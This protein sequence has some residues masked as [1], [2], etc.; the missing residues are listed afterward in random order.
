MINK[1][2]DSNQDTDPKWNIDETHLTVKSVETTWLEQTPEYLDCKCETGDEAS[3][4]S[5][6]ESEAIV[7][8]WEELDPDLM[9]YILLMFQPAVT[10]GMKYKAT[11]W[12]LV[13]FE[14]DRSIQLYGVPEPSMPAKTQ[15][16]FEGI[17]KAYLNEDLASM[18]I[19]GL[20]VLVVVV[21]TVKQL[22][23][24]RRHL[25]GSLRDRSLE[26]FGVDV[27]TTIAGQYKPPP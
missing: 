22:G 4:C 19:P 9:R 24:R 16:T 18:S 14:S 11:Y 17:V 5:P 1:F 15:D 20:E 13:P 10:N 8:F 25:T 26:E 7:E 27:E 6:V 23:E 12:G 21:H 2:L 3:T